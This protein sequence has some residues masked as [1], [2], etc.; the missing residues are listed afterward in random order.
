MADFK[1]AWYGGQVLNASKIVV[2]N[3]SKE[4]AKDVMEDAKSILKRK[5]KTTSERGLLSQFEVKK[6]LFE[7]GGYIISCQ[8]PGNWHPPYHA[9]FVEMG[10]WVHPYGNKAAP[11]VY[12]P[13]KAFMRPAAKKN[14]RKA[15]RKLRR[16]LDKL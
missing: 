15:N 12:L 2:K 3:V 16:A 1:I 8:G 5:A 6:S 11:K 14:K 9:S 10:S 7:D 13:P 4:V